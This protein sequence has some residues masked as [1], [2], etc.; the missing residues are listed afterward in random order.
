MRKALLCWKVMT[1]SVLALMLCCVVANSQSVIRHEMKGGDF[2][3]A[4]N[5]TSSPIY[6]SNSDFPGVIRAIKN[7]KTDIGKVT[8]AEPSMTLDQSPASKEVV[9]IGTVGKSELITQLVAAKKINV[10]SLRGKW[11]AFAF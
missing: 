9:I 10:E 1:N 3:L 2:T 7:L 11:E 8:G 4:A 5:G 6:A